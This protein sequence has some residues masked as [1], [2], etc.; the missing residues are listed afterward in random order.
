MADEE[1][2]KVAPKP[3]V[4]DK[5]V[6]YLIGI[7]TCV[8]LTIGLNFL[9][10]IIG[11]LNIASSFF[12]AI[13]GFIVFISGFIEVPVGSHGVMLFLGEQIE[14][15]TLETGYC[16]ILPIFMKVESVR[17]QQQKSML[18]T[19]VEVIKSKKNPVAEKDGSFVSTNTEMRVEMTILWKVINPV[20]MLLQNKGESDVEGKIK[21][22]AESQLREI[23][24]NGLS[25]DAMQKEKNASSKSHAGKDIVAVASVADSEDKGFT[26]IEFIRLKDAVKDQIQTNFTDS[27]ANTELETW[28]VEIVQILLPKIERA[29]KE[30]EDASEMARQEEYKAS[31]TKI[32]QGYISDRAKSIEKDHGFSPQEAYDRALVEYGHMPGLKI[33]SD[34]K[35]GGS[36]IVTA[37]ALAGGIVKTLNKE[38]GRS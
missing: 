13:V 6:T 14:S 15:Y 27:S 5:A 12:L 20:T 19:V 3:I 11:E 21:A 37:G 18:E 38:G 7:V 29:N 1:A 4:V 33:V 31:G 25:D 22:Y 36:D 23:A 32:R 9:F 26:D 17:V 8:A 2:P 28:G 24:A 16:W 10:A 30:T 35:K 34:D